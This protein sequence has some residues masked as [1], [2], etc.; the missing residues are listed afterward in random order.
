MSKRSRNQNRRNQQNA[1]D[2]ENKRGFSRKGKGRGGAEAPQDEAPMAPVKPSEALSSVLSESVDAAS[3]DLIR[4]ND[5]FCYPAGARD[6]ESCYVIVR[7]DVKDIG[8]L[9]KHMKADP[10]KGQFIEY[11]SNGGVEAHVTPEGLEG[12]YFYLIPSTKTL[13]SLDEFAFLSDPNRF[14]KFIV[15]MVH[16]DGNGNMEFEPVTG[17]YASFRDLVNINKNLVGLNEYMR[18][19]MEAGSDVESA[20]APA[21]A[22]HDS[23][24]DSFASES[25]NG[26]G[27]VREQEAAGGVEGFAAQFASDMITDGPVEEDSGLVETDGSGASYAGGS[28]EPS[29]PEYNGTPYGASAPEPEYFTEQDEPMGDGYNQIEC[30][31]CHNLFNPDGPCPYCGYQVSGDM[32]EQMAEVQDE[33]DEITDAEVAEACE[34]L[35]HA[36]GLELQITAQPFDI[37]FMQANPFVPL[38]EQRGDGWLDGYVTQL[39]KNANSELRKLHMQNLFTA[40]QRYLTLMTQACEEISAKVDMD[41]PNTQYA[42]MRK[43]LSEKASAD[44]TGMESEIDRRRTEMQ[45]KWDEELEQ[46][47]QSSAAAARRSYLDKHSS[48]H[49]QKLRDVETTLMDDIEIEFQRGMSELNDRRRMEAQR[50][51]DLQISQTLAAM[52]EHYQDML[53]QEESARADYIKAIQDYL[54]EHRKDEIARMAVIDETQRQKDAASKLAEEY[55]R[56]IKSIS[57]EHAAVCDKYV[58]EL[59]VARAHEESLKKDYNAREAA[60]KATE[61]AMN[62]KYNTLMD[63]FTTLDAT[64]SQEYEARMEVLANDKK[65]AEEHLAHVDRVHNKYNRVSVVIWAAIALATFCIGLLFGAKFLAAQPQSAPSDGHYSISFT[66]PN[67]G[68]SGEGQSETFEIDGSMIVVGDGKT[69]SGK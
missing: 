28:E 39:V 54:D 48:E 15:T 33:R 62:N 60:H 2:A 52:S 31:L 34:R 67:D 32:A 7:L 26:T 17:A 37:Q 19:L 51:L 66:T 27:G 41:D 16:V 24:A 55:E 44:R 58:Q 56:R 47:V 63:R 45:R 61:E 10:D 40:R 22:E 69:G 36:G 21:S 12:G 18:D 59:N 1:G 30:P 68:D 49:E 4:Q 65:A 43:V 14:S 29:L 46:I 64:K 9:N 5:T 11:I 35:F 42:Q 3:L 20:S 23:S 25:A 38:S 8:G 50:L 57:A 13:R 6:G 53:A